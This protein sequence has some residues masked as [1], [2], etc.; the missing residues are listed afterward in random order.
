MEAGLLVTSEQAVDAGQLQ[1]DP[2][3]VGPDGEDLL[4]ALRGLGYEAEPD[5]RA[6]E[7]EQ[8]LDPFLFAFGLYPLKDG[9]RFV[10]APGAHQHMRRL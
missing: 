2:R 10:P 4:E 6:A 1:P 9:S 3:Q 8:P 5:L 7:Q